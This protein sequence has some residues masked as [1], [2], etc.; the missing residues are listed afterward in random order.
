M[1]QPQDG[2]VI[3]YTLHGQRFFSVLAKDGKTSMH[4]NVMT[5][6]PGR[7]MLLGFASL[8]E[9]SLAFV[10]VQVLKLYFRIRNANY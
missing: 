8:I 6:L 3:T 4:T 10:S 2:R 7:Y 5:F 9:I 1:D